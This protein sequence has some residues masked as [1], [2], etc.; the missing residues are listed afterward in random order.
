MTREDTTAERVW[1]LH[2]LVLSVVL[3][4]GVPK[5]AGSTAELEYRHGMLTIQYSSKR[6]QLDVWF[7]RKVLS[8][9]R[10]RG[11]PQLMRYTP[12]HWEH[13]LIGI[14]KVAA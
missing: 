4:K 8:F 2:D 5:L 3:S 7:T 12:G 1:K 11:C 13:H 10:F 9:E 14:A 6:G